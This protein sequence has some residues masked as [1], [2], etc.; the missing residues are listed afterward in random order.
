VLSFQEPH[1]ASYSI[2]SIV[3][4][5][6]PGN[7]SF[8]VSSPYIRPTLAF[9][10]RCWQ[11]YL[12]HARFLC[13]LLVDNSNVVLLSTFC[14]ARRLCCS[15][16]PM[17]LHCDVLLCAILHI[18]PAVIR[19]LNSCLTTRATVRRSQ[20]SLRNSR[21]GLDLGLKVVNDCAF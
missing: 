8:F 19:L 5:D 2:L 17:S 3:S 1:P 13:A 7:C 9:Q 4:F 14:F 10:Q 15:R 6:A 21:L 12:K 20:N 18:G 11:S 16:F